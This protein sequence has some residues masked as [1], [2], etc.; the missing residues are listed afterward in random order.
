MGKLK[1]LRPVEGYQPRWDKDDDIF[2][3]MSEMFGHLSSRKLATPVTS[4][5]PHPPEVTAPLTSEVTGPRRLSRA[6]DYLPDLLNKKL[7]VS[8]STSTEMACPI[9]FESV[10]SKRTATVA[11]LV[12]RARTV[13]DGHSMAEQQIYDTLWR[14]ARNS[15]DEYREITIGYR[16]LAEKARLHRNTVDRNLASLEEK[17][18]IEI[19][20]AE[21]RAGNIGRSYRVYGFRSVLERREGAGLVWFIKN[22][23]GVRLLREEELTPHTSQVRGPITSK[24]R[25]PVPSQVSGAVTTEVIP[26]VTTE[27]TTIRKEEDSLL[28]TSTSAVSAVLSEELGY[29]D[30]EAVRR[31]ITESRKRIGDATIEEIANFTRITA[32]RIRSIRNL[33]NPIG[34]LIVQVPKC[35]EGEPFQ[36]Y[37]K[38]E[39]ARKEAEKQELLRI[40]NEI[41]RD[42]ITSEQSRRWAEQIIGGEHK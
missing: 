9:T 12:R 31:I 27:V 14:E 17:L 10:T 23:S 26:P 21:D 8:P 7:G 3:V 20:K 38:V 30:D 24:V 29:V 28:G 32:R 22:R 1:R 42:P 39:F 4:E 11:P 33:Q 5:P 35:F 25:G 40:A 6:G 2:E 37:R 19:T 16:A 18:A 13:Q 41:L 36:N 34:L 15:T